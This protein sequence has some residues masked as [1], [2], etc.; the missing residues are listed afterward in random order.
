MVGRGGTEAKAGRDGEGRAVLITTK[1]GEVRYLNRRDDTGNDDR[2]D[3]SGSVDQGR[4]LVSTASAESAFLFCH[5]FGLKST[6]GACRNDWCNSHR[7]LSLLLLVTSSGALHRIP[8]QGMCV[9]AR[10]SRN[11]LFSLGSIRAPVQPPLL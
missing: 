10:S 3:A 1:Q 4:Q 8:I 9:Q 5:P 6:F 2:D 11:G 7:K